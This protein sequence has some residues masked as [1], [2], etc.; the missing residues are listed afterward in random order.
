MYKNGNLSDQ[1]R[2]AEAEIPFAH[3]RIFTVNRCASKV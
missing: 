3:K 2:K 1:D